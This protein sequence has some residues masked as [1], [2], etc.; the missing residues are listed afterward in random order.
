MDRLDFAIKLSRDVGFYLLRYWGK[1]LNVREKSSF[2]DLVSDCDLEAQ[3]IIVEK[4][5]KSYPNDSILAEEGLF[6]TGNKIWIIDPIDGTMNYVHGLPSFGV[7]IA[8][9]ENNEVVMGVIN[10]PIMGETFYAL[11][12]QGAFVNGERIRVS[13]T[14]KLKNSIGNIGFY[15]GF[16]GKFINAVE[17]RVRR[18]RMTGSA[19]IGGAYVACGRF[20]FFIARRANPWDIAPLLAIMPEAGGVVTDIQGERATLNSGSYVF[21]NGLFHDE[22]L[23]V[24]SS[25]EE[26]STVG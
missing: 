10:D 22:L 8:Y 21:S 23:N 26:D 11:R 2:Q 17:T 12:G 14:G 9:A 24:I 20:D 3:R 16:T 15:V 13:Q 7:A 5:Q 6:E 18:I 1:A 19:V 25:V 4:I